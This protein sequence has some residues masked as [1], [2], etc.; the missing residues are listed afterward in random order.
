M[1]DLIQDGNY[2][3]VRNV[4]EQHRKLSVLRLGKIYAT[5]PVQRIATEY[6]AS[7][8]EFSHYLDSLIHDKMLPASI[9]SGDSRVG[10]VLHFTSGN[11]ISTT[12][13][14]SQNQ[15]VEQSRHIVQLTSHVTEADRRLSISKEY[16]EYSRMKRKK[17]DG[18]DDMQDELTDVSF[19]GR[20]PIADDEDENMMTD[21]N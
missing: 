8:G 18:G 20:A 9:E 5:V 13:N 10:T 21:G 15:L 3:L 4:L 17:H 1:T 2:G 19:A 11:G 7:S 16:L 6:G 14:Y 12:E